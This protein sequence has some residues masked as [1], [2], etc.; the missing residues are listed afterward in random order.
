MKVTFKSAALASL[1]AIGCGGSSGDD[2][3]PDATS[4]LVHASDVPI[5]GL[6]ADDVA[7]FRDGD[8][9]FDLP[10]RE[11][12]GLGPLYVRTACGACHSDGS[13]GPGLVQ[14]MSI[15]E[16]DGFTAAADQSA[17]AYGHSIRPGLA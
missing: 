14:K 9:L 11:P 7:K 8:A 17:L 2:A 1:F 3:A 6:S 12:D 4:T 13:R 15:V 5:D 16:A 10:F